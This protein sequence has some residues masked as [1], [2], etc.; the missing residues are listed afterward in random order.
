MKE[1]SEEVRGI[2]KFGGYVLLWDQNAG[3]NFQSLRSRHSRDESQTLKPAFMH[4]P[5]WLPHF[6]VHAFKAKYI[7]YI[8]I[9]FENPSNT[10]LTASPQNDIFQLS[11]LSQG[12]AC[13]IKNP[14]GPFLLDCKP[15][16]D[17]I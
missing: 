12:K 4:L 5:R 17:R 11:I 16:E 15:L 14:P 6:W 3:V 13:K 8:P 1:E 9:I 10:H 7:R 2:P